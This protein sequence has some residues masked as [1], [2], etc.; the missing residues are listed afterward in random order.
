MKILCII[1]GRAGRVTNGRV[2]RMVPRLFYENCIQDY[3]IPEMQVGNKI[4]LIYCISFIKNNNDILPSNK[5]YFMPFDPTEI[6]KFR[7]II[8]LSRI[9]QAYNY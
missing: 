9:M 8:I 1:S 4:M 2:Y 7:V 3:G 6:T 5:I